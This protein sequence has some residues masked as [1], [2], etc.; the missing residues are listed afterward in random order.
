MS[1]GVHL[2]TQIIDG[3]DVSSELVETGGA[4]RAYGVNLGIISF[5]A[6]MVTTVIGDGVTDANNSL[7]WDVKL[8]LASF[9]GGPKRK[10][11]QDTRLKVTASDRR[12]A[13]R[14]V[15]V[16][17]QLSE[18]IEASKNLVHHMPGHYK[19]DPMDVFGTTI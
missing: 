14:T 16:L 18:A 3:N 11:Q 10:S 2:G 7:E 9:D 17:Y 6:A 13:F 19:S 15:G 1:I 12:V 4:L 5:G 8:F